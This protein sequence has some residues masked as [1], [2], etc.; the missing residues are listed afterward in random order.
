[1][2]KIGTGKGSHFYLFI[3]DRYC[4]P[5]NRNMIYI[6]KFI[7]TIIFALLACMTIV[8]KQRLMFLYQKQISKIKLLFYIIVSD[9]KINSFFF[10]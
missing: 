9:L 3:N 8:K 2:T 6:Y 7:V 5:T 4:F 1:M 10:V